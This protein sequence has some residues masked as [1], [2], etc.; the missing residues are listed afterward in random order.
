MMKHVLTKGAGLPRLADEGLPL[1]A[2]QASRLIPLRVLVSV[3]S[4]C[5]V[6]ADVFVLCVWVECV[7]CVLCVVCCVLCVC[8]L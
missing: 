6:C 4:L 3:L 2:A 7:C 1:A 8:C 5:C